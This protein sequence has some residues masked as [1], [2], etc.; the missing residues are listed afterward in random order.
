MASTWL[1]ISYKV[2]VPNSVYVLKRTPILKWCVVEYEPK[3]EYQNDM[4]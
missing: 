2:D 3:N 1:R 4:C